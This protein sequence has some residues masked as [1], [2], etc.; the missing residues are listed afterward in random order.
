VE[1]INRLFPSEQSLAA[2]DD[3]MQLISARLLKVE[4]Q[5]KVRPGQQRR[6]CPHHV[7][8]NRPVCMHA[9]GLGWFR[10]L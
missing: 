5:I 7:C 2:I 8:S 1:Y 9:S 6:Q 3:T 10:L 4:A